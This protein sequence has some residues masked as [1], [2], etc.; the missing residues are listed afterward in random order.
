MLH[1]QCNFS[2]LQNWRNIYQD[3]TDHA[4][5]IV[6]VHLWKQRGKQEDRMATKIAWMPILLFV[7]G[8]LINKGL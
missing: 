3:R 1:F 5:G 8:L 4:E 2:R 6:N 7:F